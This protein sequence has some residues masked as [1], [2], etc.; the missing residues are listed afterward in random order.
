PEIS[1]GRLEALLNYQ[2]MIC[3]LTG[4]DVANALL[5]D[6]AT[7]AA[8][9]MAIAERV[10]KSNARA[11]FVDAYCHPQTIALIL[12]RAEPLGWNVI[13]DRIEIGEGIAD[14]D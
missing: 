1:Q 7:A 12:T 6:E 13:V 2:T 14:D 3:D 8:E 5:L 10:A 4:L 9:G 11:F